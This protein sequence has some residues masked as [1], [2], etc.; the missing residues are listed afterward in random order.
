M[1][2]AR[3]ARL[4]RRASINGSEPVATAERRGSAPPTL[5]LAHILVPVRLDASERESVSLALGMAAAHRARVTLL[6][7]LTAFEAPSAHWLDAIDNLQRALDG[8][9]RDTAPAIRMREAE[10]REFLE[11]E[12]PAAK[13]AAVDVAVA[14]RVGDVATEIVRAAKDLAA[15]LIVL[16]RRRPRRRPSF[17]SGLTDRVVQLG[18]IPIMLA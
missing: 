5:T 7:V 18:S 17:S 10:I 13:R 14:C 6:H 11:R 12:I 3:H 16:G 8:H 15:D 1:E 4:V 2:V 9:S